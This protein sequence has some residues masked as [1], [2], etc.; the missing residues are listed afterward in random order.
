[1]RSSLV[2]SIQI[3]SRSSLPSRTKF[4]PPLHQV[5]KVA[6]KTVQPTIIDT[7]TQRK[8]AGAASWPANLRI[9]PVVKKGDLKN[10]HATIR[11]RL[12][13]MLREA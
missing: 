13:Q 8:A 6:A 9:E 4:N 10:V 2:R 3:I 7:L 1:M 5:A 11:L 12:K